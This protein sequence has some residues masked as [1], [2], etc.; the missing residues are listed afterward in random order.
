VAPPSD[1]SAPAP[2]STT[3]AAPAISEQAKQHFNAG[4][5]LLQDPEGFRT[6][7]E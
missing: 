1:A 3:P 5:A 6:D 4:V 2:A 7:L